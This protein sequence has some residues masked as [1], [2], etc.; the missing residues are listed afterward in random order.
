MNANPRSRQYGH[1]ESRRPRGYRGFPH[2]PRRC[3]AR[4]TG[5]MA[6]ARPRSSPAGIRSRAANASL[7]FLE[8]QLQS[9]LNLPLRNHGRRDHTRGARAVRDVVV[10]L[11]ENGMIEGIESLGTKLH[12]DAFTE[13]EN[14]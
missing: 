7:L 8:V 6:A 13:P 5:Q 11:S 14:L 4:S 1:H 10:R 3:R 9:K 12:I 2:R